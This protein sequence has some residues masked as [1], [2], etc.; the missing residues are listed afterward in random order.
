MAGDGRGDLLTRLCVEGSEELVDGSDEGMAQDLYAVELVAWV[1]RSELEPGDPIPGWPPIAFVLVSPRSAV[2]A[3]RY[4]S[5]RVM[6]VGLTTI[7][8]G[9]LILAAITPSTPYLVLATAFAVLGAGMGMTAAPATSEIMSV[10]P[11]SKA[12]VGSAM[13]D[14]TRELG[15]ALGVAI[16]GSIANGAYRSAID[17]SG[18]PISAAVRGQ[19]ADSIGAA[20]R[21]AGPTEHA[22]RTQAAAAFTHAFNLTSLVS[23]GVIVIA[24]VAVVLVAR[25]QRADER[26]QLRDGVLE[27]DLPLVGLSAAQAAE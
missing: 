14:T 24:A 27:L 11:L 23:I 15:G 13:N 18:V 22:V 1:H 7:A 8:G 17:L 9:F 20:A 5:A 21:V 16:L 26:H 2:L 6:T 4:G 25:S 19:A 3:A 12:G 10:V